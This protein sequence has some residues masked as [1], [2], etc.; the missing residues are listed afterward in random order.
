MT[1]TLLHTRDVG[2]PNVS[3]SLSFNVS[4][5]LPSRMKC[6]HDNATIIIR[7]GRGIVPRVNYEVV[8]PLYISASQPE[9]TRVL[10]EVTQPRV[11]ATYYCT[12]FVEGRTNITSATDYNHDQLGYATTTTTITGE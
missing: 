2:Y 6:T 9:I 11:E 3:F 4:L 7:D 8:K 1:L 5:G 12:V 10:F